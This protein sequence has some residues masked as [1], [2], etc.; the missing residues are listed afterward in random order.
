MNRGQPWTLSTP[1][2]EIPSKRDQGN[3]R[4]EAK[5]FIRVTRENR[6]VGW[7]LSTVVHPYRLLAGG[8]R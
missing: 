8:A 5:L 4:S 3:T 7:T 6:R 1:T 2:C